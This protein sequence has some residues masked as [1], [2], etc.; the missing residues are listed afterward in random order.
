MQPSWE[1]QKKKSPGGP[2][3]DI[4]F[5][6]MVNSIHRA[7]VGS[8]GDRAGRAFF[9]VYYRKGTMGEFRWCIRAV[10]S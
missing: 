10:M 6:G 2:E 9:I 5:L 8:K 4:L 7:P 3:I 1:E